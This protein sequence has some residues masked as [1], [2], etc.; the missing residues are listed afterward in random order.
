MDLTLAEGRPAGLSGG[1]KPHAQNPWYWDYQGKPVILLGG[2]D[3]AVAFQRTGNSLTEFL[4]QLASVGGN[5]IRNVISDRTEGAVYAFKEVGGGKYD[6]T[7]W[8]DEY[9][10]RL[11]NFLSETAR[12]GIVVQL[13]LWDHGDLSVWGSHPWNPE[14][15]VNLEVGSLTNGFGDAFFFYTVTRKNEAALRLQQGFMDKLLS[16]T[17]QHGNVLYNIQNDAHLSAEWED[18]WAGYVRQAAR[19]RE[20]EA[21]VTVTKHDPSTAVRHAMS[22]P[23][24]YNFIDVSQNNQD[25]RGARGQGH[26]DNLMFWR[27]KIA[28]RP[29]G[30]MP[31]NN[32]QVHGSVDGVNYSAGS[33]SEAMNRLWRNIF[34]GC[35]SSR[36]HR[37]SEPRM[38]GS[39]LNPRAQTNIRAMR[40]LLEELDIFSCVPHNDLLTARVRVPSTME[41]YVTA[42]IGK[43]YAVYFPPGRYTV[44]LDPWVFAQKVKL[45]WLDIDNLRWSSP[46]ELA[47]EWLDNQHRWG[48]RG[49]VPLTTPSNRAYVALIDVVE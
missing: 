46:V 30:P 38:W 29:S 3:D 33:E 22:H 32:E 43:Q 44:N 31:I 41:A 7:Q 14:N 37:T 27:Q 49:R 47:V 20:F 9:W 45:R 39:G 23:D 18:Y 42:N 35:A 24:L 17:F 6:L 40:M 2:G 28:E 21:Y 36:F 34:A 48:F 13:T 1:I 8:N 12:R 4:D 19:E 11:D 10:N 16:I 26:W 25:S 5:Y 15:N